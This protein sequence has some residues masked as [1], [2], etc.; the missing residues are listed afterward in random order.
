M[1]AAQPLID[2]VTY[3]RAVGVDLS[4]YGVET[5]PELF[6]EGAGAFNLDEGCV[7]TSEPRSQI[8]TK[9]AIPEELAK[10]RRIF[11]TQLISHFFHTKVAISCQPFGLDHHSLLDMMIWRISS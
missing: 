8:T 7:N 4:G 3:R 11:K 6:I 1:Q 10:M 5:D 2:A 9:V